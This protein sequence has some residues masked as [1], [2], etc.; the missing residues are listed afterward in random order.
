MDT[1]FVTCIQNCTGKPEGKRPRGRPW[2]RWENNIRI[3]VREIGWE[4]VDWIH[5]DQNRDQWCGLVNMVMNLK[6]NKRRVIS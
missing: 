2:P 6:F 3:A 1:R 4:V 5:L